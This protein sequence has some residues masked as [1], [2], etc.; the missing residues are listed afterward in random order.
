[1]NPVRFVVIG[2]VVVVVAVVRLRARRRRRAG[3]TPVSRFLAPE[4][5]DTG[6]VAAREIRE[7]LRSRTFRVVTI[8]LLVVVTGAIVIPELV[9]SSS[10]PKHIGV[11]GTLTKSERAAVLSAARSQ[12][13]RAQLVDEG[14]RA[15]ALPSL[16]SGH[17]DMAVVDGREILVEKSDVKSDA[18]VQAVAAA[19][20]VEKAF[21]DAGLSQAQA[22]TIASARP[23]PVATLE[24]PTPGHAAR[25]PALVGVV[26]LFVMLSQYET[27]TLIGVLEEKQSRVVEVLLATV[28]PVQLL[29]GKLLGIG[30][31]ALA[32]ATAILGLALV[33][34]KATGSDLLHGSAPSML[35]ACLLW[36][37]VGYVFYS[38]VYAAAGS[39][40]ERQDQVQ[41]LALPLS[42][43]MI[44]GYV[45]AIVASSSGHASAFFRVL[46]YLP[47]TAPFAMPVLVGLDAV[48]WWGFVLSVAIA[49]ASTVVVARLAASIYRRAVL[50][51]GRRVRLREV[52]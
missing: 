3:G 33:L 28:R 26:I 15:A 24:R 18:V 52:L 51:T 21:A 34:A 49:A 35:G 6:L 46:A 48:P 50:R 20:G 5:G 36:L 30:A 45:M 39:M 29:G 17:L 23:V 41:T 1:M 44:L 31:I 42:V 32:Q 19:L 11:I 4:L 27:W 38:W 8:L 25:G 43:P 40:V 10:G 47:P 9:H 2:V 12:G 7:R 22:V 37:I 13:V 14:S 16:R